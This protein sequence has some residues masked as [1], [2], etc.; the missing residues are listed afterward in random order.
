MKEFH[1]LSEK[2]ENADFKNQ[3]FVNVLFISKSVVRKGKRN[4][5]FLKESYQM[6]LKWQ[7]LEY[8]SKS[9]KLFSV[10]QWSTVQQASLM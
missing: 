3:F 7:A 5:H 8:F 10:L 6:V 2:K 4:I 9:F 1:N